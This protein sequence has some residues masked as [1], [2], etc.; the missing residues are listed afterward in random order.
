MMLEISENESNAISTSVSDPDP[1]SIRSVDPDPDPGKQKLSRNI[2]KLR[3][4][5]IEVLDVLFCSWD[6]IYGD[7][8]IVIASFVKFSALNFSSFLVIK[9]LDPDPDWYSLFS[10]KCWIQIRIRNH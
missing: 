10:L 6:V 8:G 7:L 4:S 3:N 1:D 5:C 9:T 2:E